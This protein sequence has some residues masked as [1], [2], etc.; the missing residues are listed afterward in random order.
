MSQR[1]ELPPAAYKELVPD[2]NN[3]DDPGLR[4]G[5][6]SPYAGLVL[7]AQGIG[8][9]GRIAVCESCH[10]ELEAGHLPLFAQANGLCWRP[11]RFLSGPIVDLFELTLTEK[12]FIAPYRI[13]GV[14]GN[15][16][17]FDRSRLSSLPDGDLTNE[18]W[19][20]LNAPADPD[21]AQAEIEARSSY[22]PVIQAPSVDDIFLLPSSRGITDA[23]G[24]VRDNTAIRNNLI[25]TVLQTRPPAD[26][27]Q[28]T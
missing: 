13:R 8:D 2:P 5:L 4:L 23:D 25:R 24:Y 7:E 11:C 22:V 12:I 3:P 28:S 19:E 9:D 1:D 16:V 6:P 15:C 21:V 10:K 17:T 14:L 20:Q 26:L 27:G 18:L